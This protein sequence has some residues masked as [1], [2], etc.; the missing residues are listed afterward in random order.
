MLQKVTQLWLKRNPL[1]VEGIHHIATLLSVNQF[2]TVL[3][4]TSTGML[5]VGAKHLFSALTSNSSL[6]FLY[7]GGNGLTHPSSTS[8]ITQYF[9]NQKGNG[10]KGISFNCN[11]FGDGG[12]S[13][14]AESLLDN[15]S[16]TRLDFGSVGCQVRSKKK[17]VFILKK[18]VSQ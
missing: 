11:R 6:Q 4:L 14:I 15:S 1:R 17:R 12:V 18:K 7:V 2:L 8:Y 5:D 10:L 13:E 9:L 16:L 3:D